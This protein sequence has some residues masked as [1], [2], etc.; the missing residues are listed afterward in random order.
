MES[1]I[2]ENKNVP[3]KVRKLMKQEQLREKF[4]S[5]LDEYLAVLG[6]QYLGLTLKEKMNAY[7]KE[8]WNAL[9][10]WALMH[11]ITFAV[12]ETPWKSFHIMMETSKH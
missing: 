8:T 9:K 6:K 3:R 12:K 2:A 11:G 4:C 1:R 5:I 10:Q 7:P